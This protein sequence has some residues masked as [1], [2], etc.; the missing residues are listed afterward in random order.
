[1]PVT[2]VVTLLVIA[3]GRVAR[4]VLGVSRVVVSGVLVAAGAIIWFLASRLHAAAMRRAAQDLTAAP[5]RSRGVPRWVEE[6]RNVAFGLA[7]GGLVPL[8]EEFVPE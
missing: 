1:M 6:L 7:L 3:A 2:F 4:H 8:V 5:G